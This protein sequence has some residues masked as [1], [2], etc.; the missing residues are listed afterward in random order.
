MKLSASLTFSLWLNYPGENPSWV[1]LSM[2]VN[3]RVTL[4]ENPPNLSSST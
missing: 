1:Y 3:S 4:D 2:N